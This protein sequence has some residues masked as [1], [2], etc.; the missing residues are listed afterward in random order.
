[1]TFAFAPLSYTLPYWPE[2]LFGHPDF[3]DRV[4]ISKFEI[5]SVPGSLSMS[6]KLNILHALEMKLPALDAVSAVFFADATGTFTEI[7]FTVQ[8]AP[9]FSVALTDLDV[10][11]RVQSNLLTAVKL[12]NGKWVPLT[13]A[14]NNAKPV[15]VDLSGASIKVSADG[16]I[17][18]QAF[19][20]IEMTAMAI[21]D[22][23]IVIEVL[24]VQLHLS[25]LSP[26]IQDAPP[27]FKGVAIDSLAVHL[28]G[29]FEGF[30]GPTDITASKLFIGSSGFSG[31]VGAGWPT[32]PA[33]KFLGLSFKPKS[34]DFTF[35][36]NKLT[37]MSLKGE[38]T[39]PFFY[40][41]L[42]VDIG[43]DANS[44]LTIGIAAAGGIFTLT[45]PGFVEVAVESIEIDVKDNKALVR[46]SGML[47]PLYG[48]FDWP[49]FEMR[50]LSIDSD[51]HVK[52]E[53][54]WID[55]PTQKA[56]N[57]NAFTV[58]ITKFGMG[59]VAGGGRWVGFSGKVNFIK[60]IKGNAS[61]D[62]LRITLPETGSPQITLDGVGVDMKVAG[63]FELKGSVKFTDD[64][65]DKRF[66]GAA[67]L[68]LKKP[69]L[70]FD[71]RL[72]IGQRN[73]PAHNEKFKFFAMYG[74]LELP[75]GIP[76]GPSGAAI[77]G[78]AGLLALNMKPGRDP[79]FPW[80]AIP[81]EQDWYHKPDTGVYDFKKWDPKDGKAFGAGLTI[82][83]YADN[84]FTFNARALVVL[85]FPGPL[86]LIEG[87]GNLLKDRKELSAGAEPLF[88]AIAIFDAD[89]GEYT[90]GLDA[91]YQYDKTSGDVITIR[92]SLEAFYKKSDPRA[93]RVCFGK[94]DPKTSRIQARIISLFETASYFMID[95][96][97][98]QMGAWI[99]YDKQW[100]P[101]PLS[102]TLQAWLDANAVVSFKPNHF[103]G[104]LWLHAAIEL[105]AFG[106]GA[107]L[108][109]D[110]MLAADIMDPFHIK[111]QLSV[112]LELPWPLKDIS[113]D[114]TLEWGPKGH[115]PPIPA[116]L[117]SV[118]IE[119]L[120][121]SAIWPLAWPPAVQPAL[122]SDGYDISNGYLVAS[123]AVGAFS[124]PPPNSPIVPMDGR[125]SIAFGRAVH[126][127]ALIGVN[128]LPRVPALEQIGDAST[129]GPAQLRYA[130]SGIVLE[131]WRQASA[132]W[133]GVAGKGPMAANLPPL[134]GSW[135]AVPSA[136]SLTAVDQ[137]KLMLWSKTAFD[138]TRFTGPD[139]NNWFA[140]AHPNYPCVDAPPLRCYDFEQYPLGPLAKPKPGAAQGVET[141]FNHQ[142]NPGLRFSSFGGWTVVAL[143]H[144]IDGRTHSIRQR[145][146]PS[147]RAFLNLY[148][149][150]VYNVLN[151]LGAVATGIM[152]ITFD[153]P[154]DKVVT[155]DFVDAAGIA[156]VRNFIVNSDKVEIVVPGVI[157]HVLAVVGEV[158]GIVEVCL[159]TMTAYG[160][161]NSVQNLQALAANLISSTSVWSAQ[162]NVLEP[163]T[164]Y[165]LV[166]A[167]T[168]TVAA[169]A[170][171]GPQ[172]QTSYAYFK[173]GGPPVLGGFTVPD[174]QTQQS[175]DAGPDRLTN[176]VHQT[177][178]ATVAQSDAAPAMPRPVFRAY[179]V[180]VE[181]NA[182][183]VDLLYK[184][185]YRDLMLQILD[186]NGAP[187]RDDLGR[188]LSFE[189]P[190]GV[191]SNL[192]LDAA[193]ASWLAAV[194]PHCV[195][196][197]RNTI[198]H[199]QTL[200]TSRTPLLLDPATRYKARLVPLLLHQDFGAPRY[201]DGVVATGANAR[202]GDWIVVE[203]DTVAQAS[204]WTVSNG[205]SAGASVTQGVAL[206]GG[207]TSTTDCPPGSALLWVPVS[208]G[209][210]LWKSVRLDAFVSSA[211]GAAIGLVFLYQNQGDYFEFTMRQSDGVCRLIR[212]SGGVRAS[213]ADVVHPFAAA[214]DVEI[215]IE[216]CDTAIRVF[217][218]NAPAI[219][220]E[221]DLATH[222]GG[223]IGAWCW[224]N[225]AARF[226]DVRVEDQ[227]GQAA[228]A[229][230]FEFVTSNYLN[231]FHLAHGRRTPVW[232]IETAGTDKERTA[233]ELVQLT[234]MFAQQPDVE[235]PET[236]QYEDLAAL[237]LGP[238]LVRDPETTE[239]NR[240]LHNGEIVAWLVRSPEPWDWKRS[241]I[242][243]SRMDQ[244]VAPVSEMLGPVKITGAAL[245][246]TDANDEYTDLLMMEQTSLDGW[247]LEMRDASASATGFIDAPFDDPASTWL[248]LCAFAAQDVI[249]AGMRIRLYSGDAP[250]PSGSHTQ[251]SMN[252]AA[253]G[254]PGVARYP[255]VGADLRLLDPSRR[256]A[257]AIRILPEAG[258]SPLQAPADVRVLRKG[259]ATGLILVP[260]ANDAFAPGAY[261]LS[262]IY[263]RDISADD[264][265]SIVLS[266]AGNTTDEQ[267]FVPLY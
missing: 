139:W 267:A 5:T 82:G 125:P 205:A 172:S 104:D 75:A 249:K 202:I 34:I 102:I 98:I 156:G 110:A 219:S 231:Y 55:L 36:Q 187:A 181:F 186:S 148:L 160:A 152:H 44:G 251:L 83:T 57:F 116:V 140:G 178:P 255:S 24:G 43:Y 130:L 26:P 143:A 29:N 176:Y 42:D 198:V 203:L 214:S 150:A 215:S 106:I 30:G 184:M 206:A 211:A 70:I 40:K 52:L 94:K 145:F 212:W 229:Y 162:G 256:T 208:G 15:S 6:G 101:G 112:T 60:G 179:D 169:G 173:T 23:G 199:N 185:S 86:L 41:E 25:D 258:F 224:N 123:N 129:G 13:D 165:R 93:W 63:A 135:A 183:Y 264:V 87:L 120:K 74:G 92:G 239:I 166:I 91:F 226:K 259:D 153:A 105:S 76:L 233:A 171:V 262:M 109:A 58:E 266:Q 111:G 167:T 122:F 244:V 246:M 218:D 80:Y 19:N 190:W 67:L 223:T 113:K 217:V 189:N 245:G 209:A 49:S 237:W 69:E 68:A 207:A 99:G 96:K 163:D 77:F 128:A 213:L 50:E 51:G 46:I 157:R 230:G 265:D 195:P 234:T 175:I 257:C 18:V 79:K 146:L 16:D 132:S 154:G 227:S 89:A 107:G 10:S 81:P 131:K 248:T 12:T 121:S 32:P 124:A 103:H 78:F 252:I 118:A 45:K 180:G 236:R 158:V 72:T 200:G 62:G 194:D 88:R 141:D 65:I 250:Q 73:D 8:L 39:L 164:D 159:G 155:V 119:H 235:A 1:M 177:V 85:A 191:T 228:T 59:K 61:V 182:D 9:D 136:A 54:G 247:Q 170:A 149:D 240:I 134:Y 11:L 4:G 260:G 56:L 263:R 220:F 66:D 17:D 90:F 144:P 232:D 7:D 47:T 64:G 22:T 35:A 137:T 147:N 48:S 117:Q 225:A 254:H 197:D 14:Q 193:S 192:T 221:L 114:V 168:A 53:R 108:I 242:T 201:A 27:G 174:G 216:V 142:N 126:D 261:A 222:S 20:H 243:L 133:V 95:A 238:G 97:N 115:S 3:L 188:A 241:R 204:K 100:H 161:V 127:D 210:P 33:G 37:G 84:G 31:T 253:T 2:H 196:I 21:G 38:L 71:T 151:D 138:Q 28:G